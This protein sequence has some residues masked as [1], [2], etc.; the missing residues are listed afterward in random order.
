MTIEIQ[1][2]RAR[3]GVKQAGLSMLALATMLAAGAAHAQTAPAT[4]TATTEAAQAEDTTAEQQENIIVTGTL[5]RGVAPTGTNVIGVNRDTITARGVTSS[6]DLLAKIPQVGNFG[7]IPVGSGSFGLPVM[8][9]NIRNLGASGGS[10]TLVLINGHRGVGAGILQ[11]TVDPSILPPDILERVEI[12]PD[13]GSAI[14]GSDAIGGVVN[15]ITRKRFDGV[16]AN[17][18]Y[19]IA[20][21]YKA[22]DGS[23]T[24]GKDWGS[25]SLFLAYSYVHHDDV[26]GIDRDY[27]S[28]D[29]RSKGGGDFR[30]TTCAPGNITVGATTY[31]LPGLTAGTVNKC[32]QNAYADLFPRE[33]RHSVFGSLT[34]QLDGSTDFSLTAYWSRRDTVVKQNQGML[35]GT[36]SLLNPF[37]HTIAGEFQQ[38]ASFSFANVFG[39]SLTS[40]QRFESYGATPSLTFTLGKGW[41][42][43]AESNFGRSYN[44]VREAALDTTTATLALA[45]LIPGVALNPYN[46]SASSP[47]ALAAIANWE[48]Y[49]DATQELAEGRLILDGSL[50]HLSGGD[51]RVALGVEYH[52]E[53]ISSRIAQGAIG[54][55]ANA[56]MSHASRDVRSAFGELMIPIVGAENGSPGLRGLQLSASVRYDDYSDQGG[57]TNPKIGLNYKP[58]DDLTIRGN[59]GTSFHAPSL[60]DTTST[61]DSRA[62]VLPYSPFLKPGYAPTDPLRTTIVLAGG[63]P[64][65]KP[66]RADTWSAGFDWAPHA[67][68][69]LVANLT[70]YNVKFKDAIGL[71]PFLSPTLFT[72]TNYASFYIINPTLAQTQAAVGSLSVVGAPSI[73]SLYS[74]PLGPY[75]LIDARRNN[76]GAVNTDGLDFNLSY[77]R[78]TGFGAVNASIAGTYTLGRKSQAVAGGTFTDDLRNGV[79]RT[80]FVA[81]LGGKAGGFIA[82]ASYNYKGGFPILGVTPQT[83]VGSFQ[84]VDAFLAYDLGEH[85]FLKGAMLTL[86]VDNLFDRDPPWL[87]SSAAYT[88]GSTLGRLVTFGVRTR[89]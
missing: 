54:S 50:A 81:T 80:A 15:F 82:S 48:N 43:R 30:V 8:R 78:K 85:G 12:V 16:S 1:A 46:L 32:D 73:A 17:V 63:N 44:L 66:E 67:V 69:G 22:V 60:A 70:Y 38:N 19:G 57:T 10:T 49:G 28:A 88:N 9:P 29:R 11:T 42:L 61:S 37:F 33:E 7:T 58:F 2:L 41:Q 45:G 53:N 3:G 76:L 5:L 89:F 68:P 23:L 31:A 87:N 13:G 71:A 21:D 72:N 62:T 14:Y 79:G 47:A 24:A 77:V 74:G 59:Y 20:D 86:N 36:I 40:K 55:Y 64:N 56:R 25:G 35:S 6:N 39:N 27:S 4:A 26:L 52:Y 65:L 83:R 18:R 51:I 75:V 34:Q 84:T